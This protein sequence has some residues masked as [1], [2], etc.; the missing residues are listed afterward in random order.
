MKDV[1]EAGDHLLPVYELRGQVQA[2]TDPYRIAAYRDLALHWISQQFGHLVGKWVLH[3]SFW[4]VLI[5][6]QPFLLHQW[7]KRF[8]RGA[9]STDGDAGLRSLGATA[10]RP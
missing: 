5:C 2:I 6:R 8:I 4:N 1:L 9:F 10:N 3:F 7:E